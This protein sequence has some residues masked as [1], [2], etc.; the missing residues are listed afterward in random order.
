MK[1]PT[2][3]LFASMLSNAALACNLPCNGSEGI[4]S[5]TLL[6]GLLDAADALGM[7]VTDFWRDLQE[8][9]KN[10]DHG[11]IIAT[12]PEAIYAPLARAVLIA[13]LDKSLEARECE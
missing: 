5:S 12:L 11:V 4:E 13:E 1:H 10:G 9:A 3:A 2:N 8:T 6:R 7:P